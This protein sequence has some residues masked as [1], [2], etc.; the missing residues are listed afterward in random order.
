M[1]AALA[2]AAAPVAEI[3]AVQVVVLAVATE[4]AAEVREAV[5]IA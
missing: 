4:S 2:I 3:V 5:A 1:V